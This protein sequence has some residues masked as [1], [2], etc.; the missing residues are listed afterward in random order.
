MANYYNVTGW[1]HTGFDYYN[2]PFSRDV[3]NGEY[4]TAANNYF[5]VDGVAVKRDDMEGLTYIDLQG[6][7]KDSRGTQMNNPNSTGAHG[8]GGPWYSWEEVDYIRLVRTGYPGDDDFVDISGRQHDPWNIQTE[9]K[10][11]IAYYF[12]TGLK[13]L[14]RN[15]TRIF[16]SLD[17][18]T[19]MGGSSELE[20]ETGFKIRGHITEA[21]DAA[22]YNLAPESISTIEPLEVKSIGYVN[23]TPKYEGNN[24]I[25][26]SSIDL[27]QYSEEM[28][29]DAFVAQAAS[30]QSMLIPALSS[31][32]WNSHIACHVPTETGE[33]KTGDVI[34]TDYGYFD[35]TDVKVKHNLS[36]LYST[37]QLEL[38]DS[39]SIPKQYG[40]MTSVGGKYTQIENRK[41]ENASPVKKDIGGY[42]RKADY[43]FGQEVLFSCATGD[44]NV[45]PFYDLVDDAVLT[46]AI[47]T[48]GGNPVARFKKI[49]S[50]SYEYDQSVNGMTW[51][52]KA[53]VME[54]ASGSMWNQINNAFAQQSQ[55]RAV[56]E[57]KV[58]NNVQTARFVSRGAEIA[59]NAAIGAGQIASSGIS[60]ENYL[61]GGEETWAAAQKVSDAVF[62]SV[63]MGIDVY[64]DLKARK[65][66]AQSLEQAQN[67]L[68]ASLA[69]ANFQA[70][71]TNFVPDLNS[72]VFQ[73]NAFG[74]YVVNTTA[75]DR[76]RL[77]NY[78]L[79]YGYN[80]LYKPLTWDEINVKQRVNYIQCEGV[81]LKHS[82][83]PMRMTSQTSALL[84][85][86]LFLWNEKP[87]Q[88]AF[89][90]NPDRT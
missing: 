63:N 42:P 6:S 14:S 60:V 82:R 19:T 2:R 79:R 18:W 76:K 51:L 83:Y 4:F 52:K 12:V 22:G 49:R 32:S 80:G 59:A 85:Q 24:D 77:K 30:G 16:L 84:S 44:M 62:Q 34:I 45:Q 71:Y 74:V 29:I 10:L 43:I 58:A 57:N 75:K 23:D 90:N 26:V 50:H 53:I 54:G 40:L 47:V 28:S 69:Q 41:Y 15:V 1:K 61:S 56:A 81:C 88:A 67:Q 5:Q 21:E 65:F 36:I 3:L 78:F 31:V 37:G 33:V 73:P 25:I 68:N 86:G 8:P 55:N 70:P 27:T 20:I 11:F 17:E 9:G 66:K 87:N 46:W 89:A 72:A 7:V 13:P 35:A 64:A 48:P 39:F 38:Q